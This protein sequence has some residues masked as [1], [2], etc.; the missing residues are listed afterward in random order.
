MLMFTIFSVLNK[1]YTAQLF[2]VVYGRLAGLASIQQDPSTL[3]I[4]LIQFKT[5][6]V[7]TAR[8]QL[9]LL[10][11]EGL[12]LLLPHLAHHPVHELYLVL[13]VLWLV[14][15]GLSRE[16]HDDNLYKDCWQSLLKEPQ[17]L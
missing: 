16:V 1:F 2:G 3:W 9:L 10:V 14:A 13:V 15:T 12:L 11:E 8:I 5:P 7:L 6:W 4:Q 17:E